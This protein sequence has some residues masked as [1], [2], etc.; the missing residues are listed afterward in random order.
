MST[1]IKNHLAMENLFYSNKW[2]LIELTIARCQYY[3]DIN[4]IELLPNSIKFVLSDTSIAFANAIRRI[5]IADVPT[6]VI[7]DVYVLRNTSPLFDEFIAQRLGLIP[8]KYDED[9]LELNFRDE[10]DCGGIGCN[11]CTVTLTL[12]KETGE[13]PLMVYSDDLVSSQE[14]V[15]PVSKHIPIVK[16]GPNQ[17]IE[18]ECMAQLG[19]GSDHAK[20]QP[21]SGMGYQYYP[22]I[23]IDQTKIKNPK[24]IAN[25]C[26]RHVFEEKDGKLLVANPLNCNLCKYCLDFAENGAIKIKGDPSRIIFSFDTN[27]EMPPSSVMIKSGEILISKIDE[28]KKNLENAINKVEED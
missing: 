28:F 10:C 18:L 13:T 23:E 17:S 11:L 2:V 16:L 20:W 12:S 22:I 25:A 27:G 5:A 4:L 15:E 21:V 7:E 9:K 26:Y 8:L 1:T 24:K 3:M 6:L 19:R 14:G